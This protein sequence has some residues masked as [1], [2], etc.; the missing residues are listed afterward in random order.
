MEMEAR[1]GDL[2]CEAPQVRTQWEPGD[3]IGRYVIGTPVGR[4]AMGEVF[5]AYDSELAR[6]VALKRLH[7][8]TNS[9]ARARLVREARAA[10]Q[11]Q[12]PNVVAVYEI[13]DD[14]DGAVLATEWIDGVT[15]REWI[16]DKPW[17][18]AVRVVVAAGRG[19]AAAHAAGIVHRDFKP[20]NVL[21]DRQGRARVADFGLAS[22]FDS[23]MGDVTLLDSVELAQTLRA[24]MTGTIGG[25][26]AYMA[27]E[28]IDGARP[29]ARS[30]QFAFAVT[31]FEAAYGTYPFAGATAEAV[32][33]HMGRN[34]I[35][36]CERRLPV[37][38]DRAVR[39][40][41][42][43]NPAE[44]FADLG[45]LL[46]LIDRKSSRGIGIP[47]AVAGALGGIAVAGIAMLVA[48]SSEKQKCG[49]DLVDDVWSQSV[50]AGYAKQFAS[51]AP[52]RA[53][54]S[55]AFTDQTLDQWTG[56]WRLERRAACAAEPAQRR[57]RTT[58]LDRQLGELRAQLAVWSRAD[59]A[60]V[61]HA[62]LAVA[63]LP[64][65]AECTTAPTVAT[66][67]ARTFADAT[68]ELDALRRAG[69]YQEGRAKIAPLIE[70]AT[71]QTDLVAKARAF[72]AFASIEYELREQTT[73]RAHIAIAAQSAR[74]AGDDQLLA[75]ILVTD[76]AVRIVALKPAEALG[77]LD[78][79]EMLSPREETV[80][81]VLAVRGEALSQLGRFDESIATY[82]QG[83][84]ILE[85]E[86]MH[87][88]SQRLALAAMIGAT[89]SV[90]GRAQRFEEGIVELK[91]GHEIEEPLLGV[92]HP[93]VARTLHDLANAQ[94]FTGDSVNAT[95]NM[96]RA[97]AIFAES[98]GEV[99]LEVATC[100]EALADMALDAGDEARALKL[101]TNARDIYVQV[102]AN[103]SL[104]SSI[105]TTLGN[106]EE[107]HDHCTA[108]L[109]HYQASLDAA[110]E[111][112]ETGGTLAISYS[113]V[114]ACL[115]D[116]GGRDGEARNAVEAALGAWDTD[117]TPGPE[118]SQALAVLAQLEARG[119]RYRRALE[120]GDQA[121]ATLKGLDGP[122]WD[123]LRAD[124]VGS[125]KL[126]RRG[127]HD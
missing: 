13:V 12:H 95:K 119:G 49:D 58:C 6:P 50:R 33:A 43:A 1:L 124:I 3:R 101:A 100:D 51:V 44:R 7:A 38:L 81:K 21:V 76:A 106:I 77:V 78:T 74:Q 18:E 120:L 107:D 103:P 69:K 118:R 22:A 94:R 70:P 11:L 113:N 73:A 92:N 87:D 63:A 110:K 30:D 121:L 9:D 2:N 52:A 10:A 111:A 19:L 60:G 84:E 82:R 125:I 56:A 32:W 37:W 27:P 36:K 71:K 91:R 68:A 47:V 40:A 20:E 96:T 85:K 28:L 99:S 61:D 8:S 55:L 112:N 80:S 122:P 16:K 57:A 116:V 53:V 4:G 59:A 23:V 83:I 35:V 67:A 26:P 54:T 45:E 41:L 86:V 123:E 105:E 102:H 93:E 88:P 39:K 15:L 17:R 5:R 75:E 62:A 115:V 114:A 25:T 65:P 64:S 89:G 108:A 66:P 14:V 117:P 98:M 109:P 42:A 31:L 79:V 72:W 29:D 24:T 34:Q 104:L 48:P 46:D 126:W 127:R 90:M 97:R